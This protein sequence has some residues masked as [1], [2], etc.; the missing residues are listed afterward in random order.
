MKYGLANQSRMGFIQVVAKNWIQVMG[1]LFCL[2]FK[3]ASSQG[4]VCI[5]RDILV[6]RRRVKGLQ[7]CP[8][9]KKL[10]PPCKWARGPASCG[11]RFNPVIDFSKLKSEGAER[12]ERPSKKIR[13]DSEDEDEEQMILLL[14]TAEFGTG[15][16]WGRN[17]EVIDLN[18]KIHERQRQS[19][20]N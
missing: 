14:C 3:Q 7:E 13:R 20:H 1:A 4:F 15:E 6:G 18:S 11:I 12:P 2:P 16:M 8:T 9:K 17:D 10:K 19:P 5:H